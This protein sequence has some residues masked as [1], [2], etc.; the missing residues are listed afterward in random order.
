M[1]NRRNRTLLCSA[2]GL[3]FC[4]NIYEGQ[5]S[6]HNLRG[7]RGPARQTTQATQEVPLPTGMEHIRTIIKNSNGNEQ[8]LLQKLCGKSGVSTSGVKVGLKMQKMNCT[9]ADVPKVVTYLCKGKQEFDKTKCGIAARE[10][11][12]KDKFL[13]SNKNLYDSELLKSA[14][15]KG[16]RR[17]GS[18]I[19][20]LVCSGDAQFKNKLPT[21]L[22]NLLINCEKPPRPKSSPPSLTKAAVGKLVAAQIGN[23]KIIITALQ[24]P[25]RPVTQ[26][27][28]D[29]RPHRIATELGATKLPPPQQLKDVTI[30][31]VSLGQRINIIKSQTP[32]TAVPNLNAAAKDVADTLSELLKSLDGAPDKPISGELVENLENFEKEAKNASNANQLLQTMN[33]VTSE[34]KLLS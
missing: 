11:L 22:K 13:D 12:E 17:E 5:A 29:P 6:Q 15:A 10:T 7:S 32:P 28:G 21:S 2:M 9:S 23:A 18:N 19:R 8:S 33:D 26:S 30:Q 1:I 3:I 24:A 34:A 16:V 27:P 20:I 4:M 31:Y 25:A 14:M